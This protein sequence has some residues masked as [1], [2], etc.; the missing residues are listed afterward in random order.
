MAKTKQIVTGRTGGKNS[1]VTLR[2]VAEACG[3]SVF[4]VSRAL[5]GKPG[6]TP[7]TL[8][9]VRKVAKELGYN[10]S[11]NDLARRLAMRKSGQKAINHVISLIMPNHL[12]K[13]NFFFELFRGISE[14]ISTSG[15]G[16]LLLPN[17]DPIEGRKIS[18]RFPLSVVR[19][20]VDG[21][22]IHSKLPEESLNRLRYDTGFRESPI[23]TINSKMGDYPSI[24]RDE[25]KGAKLAMEHLLALGHRRI[26]YFSKDSEQYPENDRLKGYQ[27]ACKNTGIS[28]SECLIPIPITYDRLMEEPLR[29][30]AN[31]HPEATALLAHNDPAAVRAC[32]ILQSLGKQIPEDISVIGWDDSDPFQDVTGKNIL[33]SVRYDIAGIGR[34][35]A[36]KLIDMIEGN[37]DNKQKTLIPGSLIIRGSTA[38]PSAE[39]LKK[40]DEK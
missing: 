1:S 31:K 34:Q 10:Q 36:R 28:L 23:V 3:L 18:V 39:I 7:E 11:Q 14:E 33:T 13:S 9:K 2:D 16:L 30:A 4:P 37:D 27:E 17:Y 5:N 38:A 32:Y 12:E 21:L 29:T 19:G 25:H 6:V 40:E 35:T 15:Y 20:E 8:K 24:L 26:M 22:I